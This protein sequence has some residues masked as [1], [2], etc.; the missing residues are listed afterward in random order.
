MVAA[1]RTPGSVALATWPLRAVD[2]TTVRTIT[3]IG[4]PLT[5]TAGHALIGMLPTGREKHLAGLLAT[6]RWR[7]LTELD[8]SRAHGSKSN[9]E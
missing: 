7:S 9:M 5:V 2:M 4:A 6:G 1:A 3:A 8:G